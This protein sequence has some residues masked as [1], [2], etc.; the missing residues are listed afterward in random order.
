MSDAVVGHWTIN[1]VPECRS[2]L[3]GGSFDG[4]CLTCACTKGEFEE[5]S[6]RLLVVHPDAVCEWHPVRCP[7]YES[8]M[9]EYV[10]SRPW[11]R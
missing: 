2:D 6:A 3:S 4:R 7:A 8:D 11:S 1:G 10:D 9:V 5:M